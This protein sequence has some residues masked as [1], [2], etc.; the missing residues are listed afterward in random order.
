MRESL[1]RLREWHRQRV[2]DARRSKPPGYERARRLLREFLTPGQRAE[3]SRQ[4]SFLAVGGGGTEF[5]VDELGGVR[6]LLR[7]FL[8]PGQR[9]TYS[10]HGYVQVSGDRYTYR[11][12]LAGPTYRRKGRPPMNADPGCVG[13]DGGPEWRYGCV[14]S[15]GGWSFPEG[16][17]L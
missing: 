10:R 15:A 13:A 14:V 9:D 4:G 17:M 5:R 3:L 6:G 7:S 2:R 11:L 1:G 8:T 16:D 12:F